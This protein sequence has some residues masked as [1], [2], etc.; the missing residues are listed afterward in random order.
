MNLILLI[1]LMASLV[2]FFLTERTS[3]YVKILTL[4]G[5][6]LFAI[7]LI[8]LIDISTLALILILLET[9]IIKAI[10]VPQFLNQLRRTNNLRR[11]AQSQ[12]AVFYSIILIVSIIIISFFAAYYVKNQ[13]IQLSF[14]TVSISTVLGGIYFIIIHKNL[15]NHIVG[16]L[17]IENGA[18]LLSLAVGGEFP[19]LVSMAVL[20][21]ILM[22]VL[23]IGVFVNKIG[24][25]FGDMSIS[26]LNKIKD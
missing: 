12:V 13:Y 18:F 14:F 2:Y 15:F 10:I 9:I 8:N 24:S 21:D 11:V 23:I 1:I 26:S 5:T 17:I 16:F 25:T 20:I 4:Q 6:L 3:N 7:A 22:A 19:F